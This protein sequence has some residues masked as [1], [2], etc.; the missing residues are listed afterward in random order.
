M[1]GRHFLGAV[2]DHGGGSF[3][4]AIMIEFSLKVRLS[5][6]QLLANPVFAHA[7]HS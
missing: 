3:M 4:S 7:C 5:Y 6:K 2:H 1:N